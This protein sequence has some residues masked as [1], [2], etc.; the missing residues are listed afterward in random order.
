MSKPV[1]YNDIQ[2]DAWMEKH[3]RVCFQPDEARKR[4]IGTGP[5]CPHLVRAEKGKL[6]KAWTLR[7][8][9]VWGETYR[10][11]DFLDQPPVNR[12]RAAE[13]STPP[14]F[15]VEPVDRNLVPVDG[16]VD[17][18]AEARKQREGDHQ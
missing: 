15:D 8:N 11:A 7:R 5:G 10:C 3:C 9:A 12:R 14:M 2:R 6:P 1:W 16:W 18:R 4:V 13:E 17:Y